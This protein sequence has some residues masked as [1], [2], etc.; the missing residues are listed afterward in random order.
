LQFRDRYQR[1]D[2]DNNEIDENS[3]DDDNYDNN[4]IE[5]FHQICTIAVIFK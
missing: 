5:K 1:K 2:N 3:I 4:L